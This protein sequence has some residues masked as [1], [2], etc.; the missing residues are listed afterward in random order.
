[1]NGFDTFE[2]ILFY[3]L[4]VAETKIFIGIY[5]VAIQLSEFGFVVRDSKND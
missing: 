4:V 2:R 5:I 3:F 1:M